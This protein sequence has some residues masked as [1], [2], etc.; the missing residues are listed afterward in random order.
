MATFSPPIAQ[1]QARAHA[2][3]TDD[4]SVAEHAGIAIAMIPGR[5]ENRKLTTAE[6]I[7]QANRL[8]DDHASLQSCPTSA[9]ARAS[10]FTLSRRET[11]SPCAASPIPY[12][13]APDRAI[14]TPM[15]PCMR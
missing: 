5:I 4:A 7:E 2:N 9:W 12:S 8:T 6:D 11:P 3:L 10:T 15:P 14:P 13:S 1:A